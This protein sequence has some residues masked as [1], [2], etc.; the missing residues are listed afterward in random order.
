MLKRNT[1]GILIPKYT[2][3]EIEE[4]MSVQDAIEIVKHLEQKSK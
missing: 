1:K 2:V 4:Q 3:K